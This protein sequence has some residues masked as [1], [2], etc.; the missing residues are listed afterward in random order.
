MMDGRHS[1][2]ALRIDARPVFSDHV[3]VLGDDSVEFALD[4]GPYLS[5]F[6]ITGRPVATSNYDRKRRQNI[7]NG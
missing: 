4:F 3:C 6:C 5:G 1:M 2:A 7:R